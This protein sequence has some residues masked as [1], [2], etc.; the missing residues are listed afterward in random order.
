MQR[1]HRD[2]WDLTRKRSLASKISNLP[3]AVLS[4]WPHCCFLWGVGQSLH[5]RWIPLR[6]ICIQVPER[7]KNRIN[8]QLQEAKALKCI[9]R[10]RETTIE[11]GR[12]EP[13]RGSL[14]RAAKPQVQAGS[15]RPKYDLIPVFI[16]LVH[17]RSTSFSLDFGFSMFKIGKLDQ[18]ANV[19]SGSKEL[20]AV[21]M[22]PESGQSDYY[23]QIIT[24]QVDWVH[25]IRNY[26][27]LF[28]G[29]IIT[30]ILTKRQSGAVN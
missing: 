18:M 3:W 2:L 7:S 17:L 10:G 16:C 15:K 13:V 4:L 9:Y 25:P 14:G 27:K 11:G 30:T 24:A 1:A 21:I 28:P 19:T 8:T 12:E 29:I 26:D 20:H 22:H 6:I 5:S 23:N